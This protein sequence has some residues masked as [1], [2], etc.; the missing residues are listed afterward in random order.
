MTTTHS[1]EPLTP[2]KTWMVGLTQSENDQML[3]LLAKFTGERIRYGNY[4]IVVT[5]GA[6]KCVECSRSVQV[7]IEVLQTNGKGNKPPE[8][9]ITTTEPDKGVKD[10]HA[11]N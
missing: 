4:R 6:I 11:Y 9:T 3:N 5:R 7:Q 1:R 2:C 10:D 8:T